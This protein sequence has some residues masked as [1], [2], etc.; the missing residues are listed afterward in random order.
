VQQQYRPPPILRRPEGGNQSHFVAAE[1]IEVAVAVP[2]VEQQWHAQLDRGP[3]QPGVHDRRR[4][5]ARLL[6]R[7]APQRPRSAERQIRPVDAASSTHLQDADDLVA[8]TALRMSLTFKHVKD[9]FA[10]IGWR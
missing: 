7:S 6:P 3:R 8:S 5:I 2:G 9:E 4:G 1:Q 10:G